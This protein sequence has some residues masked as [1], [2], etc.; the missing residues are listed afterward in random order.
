MLISVTVVKGAALQEGFC[1][2]TEMVVITSRRAGAIPA[3]QVQCIQGSY[4]GDDY[5][6]GNELK[7]W[8]LE[9][10]TQALTDRINRILESP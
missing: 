10:T 3:R 9:E 6:A 4:L 1:S 7:T 8:Q 2:Q 5:V